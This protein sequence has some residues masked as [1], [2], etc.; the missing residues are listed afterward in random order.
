MNEAEDDG[1]GASPRKP[2]AARPPSG[3][4]EKWVERW[5]KEGSVLGRRPPD[6]GPTSAGARNGGLLRLGLAVV[7][8][9]GQDGGGLI[10][11]HGGTAGGTAQSQVHGLV[12]FADPI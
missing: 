12:R 4:K 2:R 7:V 3:I 10:A 6:G 9:D 11:Q 8:Q 5:M 1:R